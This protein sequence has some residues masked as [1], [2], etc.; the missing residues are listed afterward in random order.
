[1]AGVEMQMVVVLEKMT[2]APTPMKKRL[3]G[4]SWVKE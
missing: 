1:M 4:G 3:F 2:I